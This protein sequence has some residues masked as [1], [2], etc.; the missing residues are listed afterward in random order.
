M[1]DESEG[2]E[3][4]DP[5]EPDGGPAD[6]EALILCPYCGEEVEI[7]LDPSGGLLLVANQNSNNV[8]SYRVDPQSGLLT[9]TGQSTEVPSPM[10]LQV[11]EDFGR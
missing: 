8:V 2:L 3:D 6:T 5:D 4:D 9:P 10:F 11:T 1:R 7:T